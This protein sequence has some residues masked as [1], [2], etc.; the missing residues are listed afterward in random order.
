MYIKIYLIL[1]LV[2]F[3]NALE[4]KVLE[5][6][7][8][9]FRLSNEE[10]DNLAEGNESIDAKNE[11]VVEEELVAQARGKEGCLFVCL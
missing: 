1:S 9:E 8:P 2:T 3:L 10:F 7:V 6:E 5:S 11:Y 4:E